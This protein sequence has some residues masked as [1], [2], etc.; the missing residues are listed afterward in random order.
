MNSKKLYIPDFD[1][2]TLLIT[3]AAIIG[4]FLILV[5]GLT[6]NFSDKSKISANTELEAYINNMEARLCKTISQIE[7]AGK[8]EVFITVENTFETVYASNASIDESG[9]MNKTSKTTQKQ[10]AYS[11][12]GTNSETPVIIKQKCPE[13]CGV[14]VVCEGGSN[15]YIRQEIILSVSTATGISTQKIYVTG[16]N[17]K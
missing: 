1:K 8:T 7:G 16:G 15:P 6:A 4:V 10:L 13:I 14:L 3:V 2:K 9:D 12:N 11:S 5:S 17:T